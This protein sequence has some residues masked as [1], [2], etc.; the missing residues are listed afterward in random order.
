[1]FPCHQSG[2]GSAGPRMVATVRPKRT[3][4]G[5]TPFQKAKELPGHPCT[6]G[7]GNSLGRQAPAQS[8]L[9]GAVKSCSYKEAVENRRRGAIPPAQ[10]FFLQNFREENGCFY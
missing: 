7:E 4:G 6:E 2:S 10:S 8:L 5:T 3:A 9:P 1:M